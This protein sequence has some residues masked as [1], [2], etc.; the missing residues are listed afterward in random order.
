M[1][2][3]PT[4]TEVTPSPTDSTIAVASWPRTLKESVKNY[5]RMYIF[6]GFLTKDISK[7]FLVH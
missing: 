2:T 5:I 6:D 4:V 3:S 7:M 1:T